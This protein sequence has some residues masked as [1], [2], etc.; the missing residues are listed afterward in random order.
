[1]A[2]TVLTVINDTSWTEIQ[3][4][5]AGTISNTSEKDVFLIEDTVQPSADIKLGFFLRPGKPTVYTLATGQKVFARG[6]IPKVTL[7]VTEE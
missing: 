4:G 7:A 6:V 2:D 1:M 5:T 3:Q